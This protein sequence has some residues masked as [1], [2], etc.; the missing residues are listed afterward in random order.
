MARHQWREGSGKELR[1]VRADY[2][3]G[4]WTIHSRMRD[5]EEWTLHDPIEEN[6][7]R[8]LREV[9]W[10]KYQRRRCPWKLIEAIDKLLGDDPP[11]ESR[12]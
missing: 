9:L 4:R 5:E 1:F 2:H 6:M 7:W 3:A 8:S 10:R 12:Q 11:E